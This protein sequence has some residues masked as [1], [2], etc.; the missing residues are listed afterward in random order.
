MPEMTLPDPYDGLP[1][2]KVAAALKG[3]GDGLS[4]ALATGAMKLH[5]GDRLIAILDVEVSETSIKPLDKEEPRGPQQA[6]YTLVADGRATFVDEALRADVNQLLDAQAKANDAAAGRP[7]LPL[8]GP[9]AIPAALDPADDPERP[10]PGMEDSAAVDAV[11]T[12]VPDLPLDE[13]GYADPEA[14]EG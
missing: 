4:K 2:V 8:E 12:P 11:L 10:S 13:E 1:I 9:D 5:H 7:Q 14:G 6:K 3:A